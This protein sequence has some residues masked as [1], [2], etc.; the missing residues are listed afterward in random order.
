MIPI[1]VRA[2]SDDDALLLAGFEQALF[3]EDAWTLAMI[4]EEL[5]SEWSHF[6]LA[7]E[8]EADGSD[9]IGYGG[10]KTVGDDA[11]IMTIGVVESARGR[12]AG[13]Q[14]LATLTN[15]AKLRGARR[16][17]LEVRESNEAARRLYEG[18]G[19]VELG[20]IRNYFRNPNEDAV[21]MR[22]ELG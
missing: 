19:F 8:D 10:V 21:L 3:P 15:E 17:F 4:R 7:Y 12:G 14:I 13:A 20:R 1:V 22:A 5:V 18:A 11:D 9:P 2:A 6:V 16:V